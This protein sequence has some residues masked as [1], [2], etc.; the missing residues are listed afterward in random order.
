[1]LA[2]SVYATKFTQM[3]TNAQNERDA[4]EKAGKCDC[5]SEIQE[6]NAPE[7]N[8]LLIGFIIEM[9]F[10]YQD[11]DGSSLCNWYHGKVVKIVNTKNRVVQVQWDETCLGDLDVRVSNG[12]LFLTKWN[13]KTVKPGAW[14]QY[15]AE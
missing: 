2:M 6:F 15:L 10:N 13:S 14:R 1:M 4:R 9:Y 12:K 8:S 5:Y 11:K 7:I 3:T